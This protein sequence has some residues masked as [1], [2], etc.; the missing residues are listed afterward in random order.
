[1][2][3]VR[4]LKK[5]L[6]K[7]EKLYLIYI[8]LLM[9]LNTLFEFLSIG[10]I[11]PFMSI[12]FKKDLNFMPEIFKELLKGF[13]HIDLIKYVIIGL[14]LIY[15][16]KNLF[17]LFYNYQ[18]KLYLR[19]LQ[20][21]VLSDLYKLYMFQSYSFF[22]QKNTGTILRNLQTSRVVSLCLISYLAVILE[23]LIVI[24]FVSYLLYVNFILTAIIVLLF[25]T[26]GSILYL[27]SK[28][29]L[30]TW[31]NLK[32]S[33]DAKINQLI[34]QSFSLIKNIKIF[35]KEKKMNNF[36]KK[37]IFEY[38]DLD[39]KT[40]MIQQIPRAVIE[41]LGIISISFLIIVLSNIGKD[42]VEIL[43]LIALYA[44]VAF[45]LMPSSTRIITAGQRIRSFAPNLNLIENEFFDNAKNISDENSEKIEPLKF[46]NLKFKDV[47]FFYGK[48][49]K[50]ILTDIN[51]EINRG[52]IIGIYGESGSGKSTFVNLISGLLKPQI[53]TIKI[54]NEN[55]ENNK[56]N[57][58]AS[59]G[60]VPQQV[61]L[62]NDTIETNISF[63]ENQDQNETFNKK[64]TKALEQ[65]NLKNLIDSLPD[66]LNTIVGENAAKLSGGQVQRIG[67]ARAIFNDPEFIIFDESTSSLDL[68]NE[69]DIM[70]FV[71]SL[72][73][74][75]TVI[76]ISHKKEILERCDKIFE[77]KNSKINQIK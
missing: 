12:L 77:V 31:G 59:L 68:E 37:L 62:F 15:L 26:S 53:G 43:S 47:N 10:I 20:T 1:M 35:N 18:Q 5:I 42:N 27:S 72:K 7:K 28:N 65:A 58:L 54:N 63:F 56:P 2:N 71:Y 21:R 64:I 13:E 73:K 50:N 24:I 19:N 74:H 36:F 61:T 45:R 57:W 66:K 49:E 3:F 6:N 17:I 25:I 34:I 8:F 55:L 32:Q 70:R 44:A 40:D 67:I 23:I 76:I 46:K 51:L 11:L 14:I 33:L 29:K 52:E 30:Y 75:K 69:K 16:I 22:L 4:F 60:Y 41:M 38:E 9:V 39:L 48:N